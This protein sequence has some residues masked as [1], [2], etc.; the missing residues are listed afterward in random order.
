VRR[1]V[2]VSTS[3]GR[4]ISSSLS[5]GSKRSYTGEAC[6]DAAGE[7][8]QEQKSVREGN[9]RGGSEERR[10]D[11]QKKNGSGELNPQCGT[12]GGL[13]LVVGVRCESLLD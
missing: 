2:G 6:C 7:D 11:E 8:M 12:V 1:R 4:S 9:T 10:M 3:S 5:V 13:E